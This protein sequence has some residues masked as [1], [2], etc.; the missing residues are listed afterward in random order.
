M[1]YWVYIHTCK[2][3]GKRYVGC[4]TRVKPEL[5]WREG[6]GY[7]YNKYFYSAIQRDRSKSFKKSFITI[8]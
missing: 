6:N 2:A 1:R 3:N 8:F 7:Q 4:T 5:R